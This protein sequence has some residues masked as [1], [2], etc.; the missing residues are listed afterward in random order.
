MSDITFSGSGIRVRIQGLAIDL[1]YSQARLLRDA[2]IQ[3]VGMPDSCGRNSSLEEAA[4]GQ[5]LGVGA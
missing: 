1:T 2:L 4:I 3:A 5:M